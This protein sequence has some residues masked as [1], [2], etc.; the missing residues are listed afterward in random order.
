[1]QSAI[2]DARWVM[3]FIRKKHKRFKEELMGRTSSSD[4]SN[5]IKIFFPSL[6]EAIDFAQRKQYSYEVITPKKPVLP[7]KSYADNFK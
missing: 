2:G 7:K 1:M 4:M 5:E 3:E 6:E